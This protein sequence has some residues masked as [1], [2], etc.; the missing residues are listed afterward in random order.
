MV[1]IAT[2]HDDPGQAAALQL[3]VQRI[4]RND[5][6][7]RLAVVTVIPPFPLLGTSNPNESGG[8]EQIR[9]QLALRHWARE[10]KLPAER[11][12]FHVIEGSDPAEVLLRYARTNAVDQ[13]V[14]GAPPVVGAP[15]IGVGYK[16]VLGT[17]ASRVALD[18][19]C[20]VTL[21]RG[22]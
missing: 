9:H 3:A 20:T 2:Q 4:V 6:E 11:V 5:A 16:T 18:A 12:T 7:C 21:V 15:T 8:G 19:P 22:R 17:V 13:I 10:L 14:I 1:A